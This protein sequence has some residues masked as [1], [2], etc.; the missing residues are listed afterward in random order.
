MARRLFSKDQAV[1]L[2]FEDESDNDMKI[3][4]KY[5]HSAIF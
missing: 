3:S 4:F 1:R 2:I 5:D